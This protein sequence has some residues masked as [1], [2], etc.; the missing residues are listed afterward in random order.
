[1]ED[2]QKRAEHI[3]LAD[4]SAQDQLRQIERQKF[5]DPNLPDEFTDHVAEILAS[6]EADPKLVVAGDLLDDSPYPEV[7]AA[8]RNYDEDVPANTIRAWTI[9]LV[10][11]A[12][13]SALNMLFSMRQPSIVITTYVAQLLC[14]PV[15][16]LWTAVMPN[17]EFSTL[18]LKWNLNPGPWNVKEHCLVIIMAN[19]TYILH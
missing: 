4:S 2:R 15:G 14:H 8:V 18:G 13:G 7:R 19:G 5:V 10:F 12:I 3:E 6:G 1:M 16:L 9:G 17:R 11:A